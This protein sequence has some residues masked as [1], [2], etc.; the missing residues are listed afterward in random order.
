MKKWLSFF[1]ISRKGSN[2]GAWDCHQ[3]HDGMN[4]HEMAFSVRLCDNEENS[5]EGRME[6]R[7]R[8]PMGKQEKYETMGRGCALSPISYLVSIYISLIFEADNIA[9]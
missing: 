5:N 3:L 7:V 2:K 4:D 8:G 9:Y 1:T 6:V